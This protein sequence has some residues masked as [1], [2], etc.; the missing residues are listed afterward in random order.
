MTPK[1]NNHQKQ[2]DNPKI[3]SQKTLAYDKFYFINLDHSIQK[4][5]LQINQCKEAGIECER[6]AAIHGD[7]ITL[8]DTR[9][10]QTFSGLAIRNNISSTTPNHLYK[11]T[12]NPKDENQISF[13]WYENKKGSSGEL[14]LWCSNVI[15]WHK[16]K[17]KGYK[18][19]V[20]TEDDIVLISPA[21][22]SKDLD[23]FITNLPE[24]F[25]LGFLDLKQHKG[26]QTPLEG[27][28]FVNN[29]TTKSAGW[30]TWALAL[31]SKGIDKLLSAN[32][33]GLAI[34]NFY[35]SN[36]DNSFIPKVKCL[37]NDLS[38][39]IYAS[40]KKIIKTLGGGSEIC[41]MGRNYF[42]CAPPKNNY[43]S[44]KQPYEILVLN[45]NNAVKQWERVNNECESAAI[46]CERFSATKDSEIIINLKNETKYEVICNPK[47]KELISF[48]Y[49]LNSNDLTFSKIA[50]YC[51]Y[52][53]IWKNMAKNKETL[54]IVLKDTIIL[55][56]P[57]FKEK[58]S[59]FVNKL[60]NDFHLG[61]L[62][63]ID[64]EGN[65]TAINPYVKQIGKQFKTR[66]THAI[67][68]SKK[69]AEILTSFENYSGTV[70]DLLATLSSGI[71]TNSM[72]CDSTSYHLN[73]YQTSVK[74]LE[75]S[76]EFI[77]II[78]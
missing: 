70:E 19:V 9:T 17:E 54:K 77:E 72:T 52:M 42:D 50:E 11:I 58:L 55:N 10:K 56:V 62:N 35:W 64:D 4:H 21:S 73:A 37:K 6:V 63:S 43:L 13:L 69:A 34:D 26:K 74:L 5:A 71:E 38:L 60:P 51:S 14:G 45:S 20:V 65:F 75:V 3:I 48:N 59:I 8:E 24:D 40:S 44:L 78:I 27:N 16:I 49:T 31:S 36:I 41:A 53:Q 32:C 29:F 12:C 66:E 61:Y 28:K 30:G 76:S 7:N 25:D 22:F 39:K 23:N 18:I 47:D 46:K 57:Y 2:N 1:K 68:F 15:L 33:Y 67:V